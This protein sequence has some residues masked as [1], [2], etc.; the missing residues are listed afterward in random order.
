MFNIIYI[1]IQV[2]K[3]P[4]Q[5]LM[6]RLSTTRMTG[7]GMERSVGSVWRGGGFSPAL[8]MVVSSV[9]TNPLIS[10]LINFWFQLAYRRHKSQTVAECWELL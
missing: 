9:T 6:P 8:P 5:K 4:E 10:H 7:I 2:T 1:A 3:E